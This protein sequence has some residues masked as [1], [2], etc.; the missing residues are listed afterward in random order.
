MT[1]ALTFVLGIA[2][3]WAACR[4]L[5]VTDDRP[6]RPMISRNSATL[7]LAETLYFV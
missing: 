2:V 5:L 1:A 3:G 7:G 6:R 4:G